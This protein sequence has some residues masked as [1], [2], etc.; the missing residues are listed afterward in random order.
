MDSVID[1]V[2]LLMVKQF[3]SGDL[4]RFSRTSRQYQLFVS[5][6]MNTKF[7]VARHLDRFFPGSVY[8]NFR[9]LQA[10]TGAV[11]FGSTAFN[12]FAGTEDHSCVLDVMIRLHSHGEMASW[13]LQH[14]YVIRE[15][16][17]ITQHHDDP[18]SEDQ[19]GPPN[20]AKYSNGESTIH[21]WIA[22][23]NTLE[24]VI[25]AN[26]TCA[27]NFITANEAMSLYPHSTFH[28]YQSLRLRNNTTDTTDTFVENYTRLGWLVLD[29]IPPIDRA[30]TASDFYTDHDT[31]GLRYV[32]DGKCWS[33]PCV[34]ESGVPEN[35][36]FRYMN[37][38]CLE[39]NAEGAYTRFTVAQSD[40]LRE[41]YLLA[42][43]SDLQQVFRRA[44][45]WPRDDYVNHML[46]QFFRAL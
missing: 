1:D 14:G 24:R 23:H 7:S 26:L 2:L 42:W 32:G 15:R 18:D 13:L 38:W 6:Y 43:N 39:F 22:Y 41:R 8:H 37:S 36:M 10:R 17:T 3:T 27:M 40:E 5:G 35:S 20:I 4:L 30:V 29:D 9:E 34:R 16:A 44:M 31:T 19:L 46:T 21:V 33:I 11:I 45:Y 12:F 25:G 28:L